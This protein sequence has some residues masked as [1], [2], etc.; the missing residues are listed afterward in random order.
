MVPWNQNLRNV[1]RE[2]GDPYTP[3]VLDKIQF[4]RRQPDSS[5]YVWNQ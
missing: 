3:T 2:L 4:S 1:A 5:K